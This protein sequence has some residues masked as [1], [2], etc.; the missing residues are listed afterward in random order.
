MALNI[1]VTIS[2][3]S[4]SEGSSSSSSFGLAISA[5]PMATICCWPPDS[6][7]AACWSLTSSAGNSASTAARESARRALAAGSRLP[8]S[9]FS[10]T[11]ML[12]N[13]RRPSGTMAMPASQ[14]RCGG[15]A[16]M[17]R[18]SNTMWPLRAR[19]TPASV[20]ISV[21]LPAPL[22][23]TVHSSSCARSSKLTPHSAGAAP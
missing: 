16:V 19:S 12:P 4:P 6:S 14:N 22:G 5:R 15:R 23:P 10:R 11:L 18:P 7:P 9:R 13:R 21:V 20:L 8:I 1:S 17:S 3:D 2:G